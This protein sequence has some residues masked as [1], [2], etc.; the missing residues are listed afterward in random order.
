MVELC[1]S[2]GAETVERAVYCHRCGHRLADMSNDSGDAERTVAA[3]EPP[4]P[5]MTETSGASVQVMSLVD[6]DGPEEILWSG[7]YSYRAVFAAWILAGALTVVVGAASM[8]YVGLLDALFI[9]L[10][11]AVVFLGGVAL[12]LFYRRLNASYVLTS[13]HFVV[14]MCMPT[15]MT[16]RIDVALIDDVAFYQGWIERCLGVGTV[17]M[18]LSGQ[19]DIHLLLPGIANVEQVALQIDT[20]RREAR[21]RRGWY[22]NDV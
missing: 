3:G 1:T 10:V 22:I 6:L 4:V 7:T 20:S 14:D 5:D 13:S 21:R 19:I 2:C 17:V 11:W 16:C 18:S 15:R 9:V 8:R 12:Y